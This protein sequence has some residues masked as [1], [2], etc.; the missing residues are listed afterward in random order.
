MP[1][2]MDPDK[3]NQMSNKL[4]ALGIW[5]APLLLLPVGLAYLARAVF[6][7]EWIFALVLVLAAAIGVVVYTIGLE[8]ASVYAQRNREALLNRLAR[9]DDPVSTS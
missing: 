1:R 5:S 7:S 9:S 3:M 6:E 2:A 8:S 4:Q